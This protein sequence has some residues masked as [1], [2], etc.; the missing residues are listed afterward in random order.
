ML[1]MTQLS[2]C[3]QRAT[4]IAVPLGARSPAM[5]AVMTCKVLTLSFELALLR[6]VSPGLSTVTRKTLPPPPLLFEKFLPMV[7]EASPE[8]SLMM[9]SP[10]CTSPRNLVVASGLLLWNPCRLPMVS[11]TKPVTAMFGTLIGHRKFRN[12]F[13]CVWLLTG[14]LSR[15]CLRNAVEFLAIANPLPFVSIVVSADPLELPGFTTVRIL[16]VPILR[17]TFCRTLPLL[18]DVR[19]PP[20]SNTLPPLAP[21]TP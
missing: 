12:S 20:M 4:I 2:N 15:L 14:T 13:R 10:L 21:H 17:L 3:R 7:C 6:T 9:V 19:R 18:I 11:P 5:F 1:G 16:L 8:L